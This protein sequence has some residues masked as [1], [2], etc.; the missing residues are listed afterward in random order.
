MTKWE[1]GRITLETIL[2]TIPINPQPFALVADVK[3]T[4]Q[5]LFH[6]QSGRAQPIF[7]LIALASM[8]WSPA[9]Q[10]IVMRTIDLDH[11]SKT[12]SPGPPVPMS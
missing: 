5:V 3:G 11:L 2:R 1:L 8:N 4:V 12:A 7:D 6:R 10:P 9:L